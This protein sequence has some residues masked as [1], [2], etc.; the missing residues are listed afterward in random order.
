LNDKIERI[1]T[2]EK[3]INEDDIREIKDFSGNLM[4]KTNDARIP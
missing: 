1:A 3:Q 4:F 2:L